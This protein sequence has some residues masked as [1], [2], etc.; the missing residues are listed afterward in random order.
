MRVCGLMKSI[1]LPIPAVIL[2]AFAL[3]SLPAS[4]ARAEEPTPAAV[5]EPDD[6]Q[7]RI[8]AGQVEI[9][10]NQDEILKGQEE[11]RSR[12]DEIDRLKAEV[13][14]LKAAGK[15]GMKFKP[16]IYLRVRPDFCH[17][18]KSLGV[19]VASVVPGR[20]DVIED[21][22]SFYV[23][24]RLI[25][26]FSFQPA[27]GFE[28]VVKIQDSRKWGEETSFRANNN[29]SLDIFEA[30]FEF[31]DIANSGLT[32]R[33]GRFTMDYGST[34]HVNSGSSGSTGQTYDGARLAWHK[35]GLLKIDAFTTL[36]KSGLGPIF[37]AD[38]KEDYES[39]SGLYIATDH[40]V[41]WVDAELYGFYQDDAFANFTM[42]LGTVGGR[43][44]FRPVEGLKIS[45]EAA[46]QFGRV[47]S[48]TQDAVMQ[49]SDH[50]AT[51]FLADAM[52]EFHFAPA[53]PLIGVMFLYASG[54]SNPWDQQSHAF[55]PAFGSTHNFLGYMDIFRA[56]GIWD[57]APTF[58]L[59]PV[60]ELDIWFD[61]HIFSQTSDGGFYQ[62]FNTHT[63][64]GTRNGAWTMDRGLLIPA[65]N[66][67]FIGH[68]LDITIFWRPLD[69]IE[70]AFAYCNFFPGPALDGAGIR[71]VV[72]RSDGPDA[73][74]DEATLGGR[75]AHRA[76]VWTTFSY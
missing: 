61:Y 39:F 60:K 68:E 57:I 62:H 19:R 27:S 63:G 14:A 40:P 35:P 52:Y 59:K 46:V 42:K 21:Q 11:L 32:F 6:A 43:V 48:W 44:I 7:A 56:G 4:A 25:L 47:S 51:V 3:L 2:A 12:Y 24:S 75:V 10:R 49:T 36:V 20:P 53:K 41:R 58:R 29:N 50:L 5:S 38:T 72:E 28:T 31:R 64:N 71:G 1:R 15:G 16:S 66:G 76:L 37:R 34:I 65:G 73:W 54:D 9:L 67:S 30:Y 8:L 22:D 45:G 33:A 55:R 26:G 74:V 17:N 23:G 18:V 13:D 69:W 70:V